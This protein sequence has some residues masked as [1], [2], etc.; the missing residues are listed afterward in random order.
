MLQFVLFFC[1]AVP[2]VFVLISKEIGTL[3]LVKNC[4]MQTLFILFK[5]PWI[6]W[7][8]MFSASLFKYAFIIII[9]TM[10]AQ[11]FLKHRVFFSSL[12]FTFRNIIQIVHIKLSLNLNNFLAWNS[13]RLICLLNF[14][15]S[16]ELFIIKCIVQL[17]LYHSFH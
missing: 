6:K 8:E 14:F 7:Y 13:E 12:S 9:Y 15:S 10:N 5:I 16:C 2:V 4:K 11:R 17:N 3:R 1:T